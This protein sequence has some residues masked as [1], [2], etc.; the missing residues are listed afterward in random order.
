MDYDEYR[1]VKVAL[2][3]TM[4]GIERAR[5]DYHIQ[6]TRL[7]QILHESETTCMKRLEER[8]QEIEYFLLTRKP[9]ED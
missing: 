4:A 9:L 2:E 5:W 7:R 6:S 3:W 8:C 1:Q